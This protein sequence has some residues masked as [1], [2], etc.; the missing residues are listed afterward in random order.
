[1]RSASKYLDSSWIIQR[2]LWYLLVSH[3][4]DFS[5]SCQPSDTPRWSWG[6]I[7]ILVQEWL[8]RN[9][10]QRWRR[11]V[12]LSRSLV[13]WFLAAFGKVCYVSQALRWG[14][15][16]EDRSGSLWWCRLASREKETA[17]CLDGVC[18]FH[19]LPWQLLYRAVA[20]FR[21]IE[22]VIIMSEEFINEGKR[23]QGISN[24]P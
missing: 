23:S 5:C 15:E 17:R 22:A 2:T 8:H 19:P 9:D 13:C 3:N 14:V 7:Q 20:C 10:C 24:T 6:W 16:Y 1:M 11:N 18:W 21:T 4:T 12:D